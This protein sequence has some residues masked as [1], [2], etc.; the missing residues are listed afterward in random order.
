MQES[1]HQKLQKF[2][3]RRLN[4]SRSKVEI[5]DQPQAGSTAEPFL[6]VDEFLKRY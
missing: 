5:P 1:S 3:V 4:Q 2:V 6:I